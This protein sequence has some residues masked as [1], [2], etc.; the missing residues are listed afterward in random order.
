MGGPVLWGATAD[1]LGIRITLLITGIAII[2]AGLI[3]K[4][5]FH[6]KHVERRSLLRHLVILSKTLSVFYGCY[7]KN[8]NVRLTE[9]GRKNCDKGISIP[10][11]T[12]QA[13]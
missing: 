7:L 2:S 5:K 4:L 3:T 6:L 1:K 12:H 9:L 8:Q 13:R 10:P 11:S